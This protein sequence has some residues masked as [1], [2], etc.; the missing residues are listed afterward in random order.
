M[1]VYLQGTVN[2]RID[3]PP[4]FERSPPLFEGH[5]QIEMGWWFHSTYVIKKNRNF[6]FFYQATIHETVKLW[7]V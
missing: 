2:V 3:L 6:D 1:G 5:Y 4:V 7:E